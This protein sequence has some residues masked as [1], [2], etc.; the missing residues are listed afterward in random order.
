[1]LD[2]EYNEAEVKELFK[3]EGREEGRAAGIVEGLAKG[4]EERK[5]LINENMLL[6]EENERLRAARA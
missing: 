2:T 5:R 6:R 3:E 1:M 4:E